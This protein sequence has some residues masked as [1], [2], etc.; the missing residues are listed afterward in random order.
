M[1]EPVWLARHEVLA[2]HAELLDRFG[3]P[4]GVRDE[5]MLRSAL[6]RARNRFAYE[7]PAPDI[8]ALAAAYAEGIVGNH[9]FLD[10]NKRTGFVAAYVFLGINGLRLTAPEED[11]VERTLALAARA[12]P[13]SDY[14]DWLRRSCEPRRTVKPD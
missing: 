8:P 7:E 11:A 9:P 14:A 4:D 5:G 12:I 2:I 13:E 3:G 6:D 1:T 10:G